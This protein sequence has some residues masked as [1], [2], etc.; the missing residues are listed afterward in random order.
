[1]DGFGSQIATQPERRRTPGR[2]CV[3]HLINISTIRL[4]IWLLF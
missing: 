1:M 4:I 2:F 3:D